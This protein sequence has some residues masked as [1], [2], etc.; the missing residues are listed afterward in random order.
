[1]PRYVSFQCGCTQTKSITIV[2]SIKMYFSSY[3]RCHFEN[4]F[5]SIKSG[6]A[7]Q[8]FTPVQTSNHAIILKDSSCPSEK[9]DGG[10]RGTTS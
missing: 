8:F 4:E 5:Y 9:P 7:V 3:I 10:C 1:M 6:P 2:K